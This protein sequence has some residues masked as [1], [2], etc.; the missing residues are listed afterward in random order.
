MTAG[1][2]VIRKPTLEKSNTE[3]VNSLRENFKAAPSVL[4]D[5]SSSSGSDSA[6]NG[7]DRKRPSEEWTKVGKDGITYIPA[8]VCVPE[9]LVE[10]RGEYDVTGMTPS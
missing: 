10:D 9:V 1:A 4:S 3:L 6:T 5:S 7:H 2:E 8:S